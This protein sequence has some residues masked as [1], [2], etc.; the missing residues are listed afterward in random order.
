[1]T[2]VT[3]GMTVRP[4][5][6]VVRPLPVHRLLPASLQMK[7]DYTGSECEQA[8]KDYNAANG[9]DIPVKYDKAGPVDDRVVVPLCRSTR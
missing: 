1:M 9:V 5:A 8:I 7:W 6:R 3:K 2:G 4:R